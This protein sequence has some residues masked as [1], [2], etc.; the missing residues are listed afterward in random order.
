MRV[1]LD[2]NPE[3]LVKTYSDVVRDIP[4]E[5]RNART[6]KNKIKTLLAPRLKLDIIRET[7]KLNEGETFRTAM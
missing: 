3:E 2:E 7:S 6:S 4:R 1:F 5:K